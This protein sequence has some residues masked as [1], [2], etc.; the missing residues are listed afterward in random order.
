V[1]TRFL[2]YLTEIGV[3]A[4]VVDADQPAQAVLDAACLSIHSQY[5]NKQA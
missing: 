2:D 1:N 3:P 5:G 4:V